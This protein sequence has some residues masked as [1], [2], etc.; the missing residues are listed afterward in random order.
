[1]SGQMSFITL[2][3]TE[4]FPGYKPQKQHGVLGKRNPLF[5]KAMLFIVISDDQS[6][7]SYL[8][9]RAMNTDKR[10]T[11]D[12]IPFERSSV[13]KQTTSSQTVIL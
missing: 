4:F 10:I 7:G 1:M 13:Q 9:L 3:P 5:T 2:S 11:V 8:R 12:I 6:Y